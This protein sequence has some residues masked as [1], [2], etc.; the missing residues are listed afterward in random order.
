MHVALLFKTCITGSSAYVTICMQ[1]HAYTHINVY[2]TC[3]LTFYVHVRIR[4]YYIHRSYRIHAYQRMYTHYLC[5]CPSSSLSTDDLEPLCR[6]Y[7]CF[8]PLFVVAA[9]PN[10]ASTLGD[11]TVLIRTQ[12]A[13]CTLRM[14]PSQS[15]RSS[16]VYI[17]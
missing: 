8:L 16:L 7:H 13:L 11:R 10:V 5:T 3:V 4:I 15:A 14:P 12:G 9:Q 1:V 6:A 2:H 17:V